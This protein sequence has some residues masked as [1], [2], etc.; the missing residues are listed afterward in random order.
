MRRWLSFTRGYKSIRASFFFLAT[1][2]SWRNTQ[3][4]SSCARERERERRRGRE[5]CVQWCIC[6]EIVKY[7]ADNLVSSPPSA[8]ASLPPFSLLLPFSMYVTLGERGKGDWSHKREREREKW[9]MA[10]GSAFFTISLSLVSR[11]VHE[12]EKWSVS[13]T[14]NFLFLSSPAP[15]L[16]TTAQGTGWWCACVLTGLLQDL[17][18]QT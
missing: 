1:P 6:Y 13:E 16:M 3:T 11:W 15:F 10:D 12:R 4:A 2:S 18:S 5:M 9:R 17:K 7:H 8:V 14:C